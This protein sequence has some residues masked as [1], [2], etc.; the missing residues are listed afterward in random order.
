MQQ[1]LPSPRC[2]N[3]EVRWTIPDIGIVTNGNVEKMIE[4]R[5]G[6]IQEWAEAEVI[7]GTEGT[8]GD[9]L[10]NSA[11]ESNVKLKLPLFTAGERVLIEIVQLVV[12][13]TSKG[14]T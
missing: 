13:E 14:C 8:F 2:R 11:L 5:M 7:K 4:N 10:E 3:D 12:A 1:S 6:K 9:S